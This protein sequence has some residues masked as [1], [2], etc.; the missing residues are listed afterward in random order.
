MLE[1]IKVKIYNLLR[2]SEAY[3]KTDMVYLAKGGFWLTIGQ[4][5]TSLSALLLAIVYANFLT[6]DTYGIYK[7]IL[8][9]AAIIGSFTVTGLGPAVV[10]S[11]SR[12]F[13][14]IIKYAFWVNI[15]W[16][17]FMSVT[18]FAGAIYYFINNNY[19]L[20]ASFII[21]GLF[22]PI[23]RSAGLYG[24]FLNGKKEFKT[25]ATYEA[26]ANILN[27]IFISATAILTNNPILL[28]LSYFISRT[29]ISLLFY[30]KTIKKFNPKGGVEK[31]GIKFGKHL[32]IINIINA[33]SE[34]LDNIL[35][36]HYLGAP[37]LAIYSFA[38]AVPK[39][40]NFFKKSIQSLALPKIAQ[41]SADELKQSIP[42]KILKFFLLLA[43]AVFAYIILAPYIYLFL[44]P[45]YIESVAYSQVFALSI[46][47]LPSLFYTQFFIVHSMKKD[48]YIANTTSAAT[49]VVSLFILLPTFQIWGAVL[50]FLISRSILFIA[51]T[52]LFFKPKIL[53]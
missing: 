42:K 53:H 5:F 33:L 27:A 50:S 23:A 34:N 40:F 11:V 46:L 21:I 36:F 48:L 9:V 30:L 52:L 32:S 7:Y 17:A 43:C 38:T 19:T 26:T 16:S 18:A 37:Q 6:K 15:K 31:G 3:T 22:E 51:L 4:V 2:W 8:S 1:K 20:A 49:H 41:R 45:Q 35:I 13:E 12:G 29:L 14:N 25:S 10:R 44:F 24:S 39:Q 28:I 47:F